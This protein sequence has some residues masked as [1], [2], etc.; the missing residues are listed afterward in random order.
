ML[1]QPQ[2]GPASSKSLTF[3]I[4]S[5]I[6]LANGGGNCRI[7]VCGESGAG[8]S[9]SVVSP[10]FRAVSRVSMGGMAGSLPIGTY[11]A[12]RGQRSMNPDDPRAGAGVPGDP[13][14]GALGG[15]SPAPTGGRT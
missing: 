14:D 9:M 2:A 7:G 5:G 8:R 1:F 6:V 11:G 15:V 13:A 10:V 4:V 3:S 12:D